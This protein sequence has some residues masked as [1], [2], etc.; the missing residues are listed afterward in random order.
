[1]YDAIC[2]SLSGRPFISPS[3]LS[4][5]SAVFFALSRTRCCASRS[6][7][8]RR[9]PNGAT[10]RFGRH[11][12]RA[13]G[14][15]SET[16]EPAEPRR[17]RRVRTLR[18]DALPRLRPPSVADSATSGARAKA[19]PHALPSSEDDQRAPTAGE[20][21]SPSLSSLSS[22]PTTRP[23]LNFYVSPER[24]GRSAAR[25]ASARLA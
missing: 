19:R 20:A 22:D 10:H 12:Q 7:P 21:S 15:R 4:I 25:G 3:V 24:R 16:R 1:M 2:P 11:R 17:R 8:L 5:A 18:G 14:E 6:A 13:G 23:V 9:L